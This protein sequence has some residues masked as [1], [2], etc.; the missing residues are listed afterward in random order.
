MRKHSTYRLT[1]NLFASRQSRPERHCYLSDKFPTNK[2]HEY[3]CSSVYPYLK[4]HMSLGRQYSRGPSPPL[5]TLRTLHSALGT[6]PIYKRTIILIFRSYRS[7]SYHSMGL[8]KK[9]KR[10]CEEHRIYFPIYIYHIIFFFLPLAP[11]V[12]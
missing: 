4:Y 9:R 10:H 3:K 7:S 12:K 5:S 1:E 2:L 8:K 11:L 6:Y